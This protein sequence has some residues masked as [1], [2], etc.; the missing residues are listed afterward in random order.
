MIPLKLAVVGN[1]GTYILKNLW[2]IFDPN[3]DNHFNEL[4]DD[5]SKMNLARELLMIPTE[6]KL[7]AETYCRN[8]DRTADYELE[9]IQNINAKAKPEVTWSYLKTEYVENLLNFLGWKYNFKQTVEGEDVI[10]PEN[11]PVIMVQYQD[12]IGIRTIRAYLG[13]SIDGTLVE[14]NGSN[15]WENFRIAFPER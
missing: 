11:A 13:A 12:F 4:P 8:A 15:Y 9:T 6:V 1:G 2:E 10:V 5:A 14:Y 7:S 3:D